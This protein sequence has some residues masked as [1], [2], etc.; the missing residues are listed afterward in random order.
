MTTEPSPRPD[1]R[2]SLCDNG[3]GSLEYRVLT[4]YSPGTHEGS[5][6]A[7]HVRPEPRESARS[8]ELNPTLTRPRVTLACWGLQG[9]RPASTIRARERAAFAPRV[10]RPG[11][12]PDELY[13]PAFQ[14]VGALGRVLGIRCQLRSP[15]RS[16]GIRH[17]ARSHDPGEDGSGVE[18][19][20]QSAR[21]LPFLPLLTNPK[22]NPPSQAV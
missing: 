17:R 16:L 3:L 21:Q 12:V 5:H 14:S 13:E 19:P 1:C 8:L 9:P 4:Q 22:A 15:S 10:T 20:C 6:A 2:K 7:V 11:S 18:K